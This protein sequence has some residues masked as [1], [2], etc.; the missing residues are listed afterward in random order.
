[1]GEKGTGQGHEILVVF[2][3]PFEGKKI[4]L[5]NFRL[6][7]VSPKI[8][9]PDFFINLSG[10]RAFASKSMSPTPKVR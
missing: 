5:Q 6:G 10:L 7:F 9:P 1:L 2:V 3:V 8:K 4:L